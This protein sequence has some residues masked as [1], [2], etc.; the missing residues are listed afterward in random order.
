VDRFYDGETHNPLSNFYMWNFRVSRDPLIW[1][2]VEHYYQ[3]AKTLVPSERS[4][5][6]HAET[7]GQAKRLGRKATLRGNWEQIKLLVMREGLAAKF[8]IEDHDIESSPTRFLLDTGDD[9]LV[10][11]NNWGDRFWGVDGTGDN[12]LGHLLMARRA[13]L[14]YE[15]ERLK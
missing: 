10:E 11:G 2:S 15:L 5:I 6:H 4:L 1:L 8:A 14:R 3:A 9:I 12:W 13:E 7:P